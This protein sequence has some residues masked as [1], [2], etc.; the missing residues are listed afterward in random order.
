MLLVVEDVQRL[1]VAFDEVLQEK[2][3]G[4]VGQVSTNGIPD[5]ALQGCS[6]LRIFAHGG[7]K[8]AHGGWVGDGLLNQLPWIGIRAHCFFEQLH[9]LVVFHK[10]YTLFHLSHAL[11]HALTNLELIGQRSTNGIRKRIEN[12]LHLTTVQKVFQPLWVDQ[13]V[14]VQH[15]RSSASTIKHDVLQDACVAWVVA[16]DCIHVSDVLGRG[17]C[18]VYDLFVVGVEISTRI[19]L[20]HHQWEQLFIAF[21]IRIFVRLHPIPKLLTLA[22]QCATSLFVEFVEHK[23]FNVSQNSFATIQDW[24]G[25]STGS[26]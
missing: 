17:Q 7:H 16:K 10:L 2:R 11:S 15:A 1:A 25:F 24:L 8:L 12:G 5:G 23:F 4:R 18:F 20:A 26:T 22:F 14:L 21:G 13:A 19:A 9:E 6:T 3:V